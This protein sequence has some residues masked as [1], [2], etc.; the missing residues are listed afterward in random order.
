MLFLYILDLDGFGRHCWSY[1]FVVESSFIINV[2]FAHKQISMNLN[3]ISFDYL[4]LFFQNAEKHLT[5]N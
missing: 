2:I 5:V 1:I 3:S 4:F